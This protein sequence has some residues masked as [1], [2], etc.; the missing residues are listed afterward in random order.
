MVVSSAFQFSVSI[1]A[2]ARGAT[3]ATAIAA[4]AARFRSTLPRGERHPAYQHVALADY[5]SI[6]A[7]AP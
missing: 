2:P 3:A 6:H 4:I 7:P 5:V 1:H